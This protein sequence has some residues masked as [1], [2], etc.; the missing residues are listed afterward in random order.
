[1]SYRGLLNEQQKKGNEKEILI[2]LKICYIT[3]SVA[4]FLKMVYNMIM[5]IPY[6][7]NYCYFVFLAI[8]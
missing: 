5:K 2:L 6:D 7:R 1:M 4:F 8:Q 3:I